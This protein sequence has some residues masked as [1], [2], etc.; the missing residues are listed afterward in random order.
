MYIYVYIKICVCSPS[1]HFFASLIQ[2]ISEFRAKKYFKTNEMVMQFS[3][4]FL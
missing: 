2:I 3:N 4:L 1:S